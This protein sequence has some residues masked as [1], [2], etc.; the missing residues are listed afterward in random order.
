MHII[1]STS[2]YTFQ[3]HIYKLINYIYVTLNT[4]YY[5]YIYIYNYTTVCRLPVTLEKLFKNLLIRVTKKGI[6]I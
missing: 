3:V 2:L 5:I 4:N 1:I 6:L